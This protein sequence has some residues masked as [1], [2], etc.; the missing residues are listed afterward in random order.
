M[1]THA[2]L[3]TIAIPVY[4]DAD[5]L[6][7]A[8][9]KTIEAAEALN[10]PFE[11]IIMED[12]GDESCAAAA[13]QLAASD[14]RIYADHGDARRGKGRAI[15]DA[16]YRARGDIFCFFDVD[17]STD[18]KHLEGLVHKIQAGTDIVIGSRML[19]ESE[20]IRSENREL[21]SRVFNRM[22]QVLLGSRIH[23]HQ[24]GFKGFSTGQLLKI[25]PYV[26]S[27]GWMW[28]AE[29]LAIAAR[30]GYSIEEM[31][32]IWTQGAKT[33]VRRWDVFVMGVS[34]FRLA[35]RIRVCRKF[36]HEG[37]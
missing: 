6:C 4:N 28:D 35:W 29:V 22:V 21:S 37:R 10:I 34:I 13:R 11:I 15:S 16:A 12:G 18:L 2:P 26:S 30:A 36:P 20:V 27:H 3:L 17:L 9:P 32:V 31:P 23:D 5:G 24:C 8:V 33:N 25:L 14:S 7:N 19:A 1:D